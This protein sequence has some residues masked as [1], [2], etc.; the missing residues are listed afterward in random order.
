MGGIAVR[1]FSFRHK[2]SKIASDDRHG[3]NNKQEEK[4]RDGDQQ[5]HHDDKM[6]RHLWRTLPAQTTRAESVDIKP[7]KREGQNS[8]PQT[9][10]PSGDARQHNSH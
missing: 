10:G 6:N 3:D 5:H 4:G 1:M 2:R 8:H 9:V 7:A